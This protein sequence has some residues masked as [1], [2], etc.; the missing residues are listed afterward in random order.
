[1]LAHFRQDG[2]YRMPECVLADTGDAKI[3]E[4]GLD[5]ALHF[6]VQIAPPGQDPRGDELHVNKALIFDN[7]FANSSP[8]FSTRWSAIRYPSREPGNRG[9]EKVSIVA[10]LHPS[11]PFPSIH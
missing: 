10:V 4:Y 9:F 5:L 3:Q 1:M 6:Q 7:S 2:S 8:L 11:D